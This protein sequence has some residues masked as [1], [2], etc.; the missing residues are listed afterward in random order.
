MT[1]TVRQAGEALM[2]EAPEA[3]DY[4]DR[5]EMHEQLAHSTADLPARRMHLAMAAEF[6]RR[7]KEGPFAQEV[8]AAA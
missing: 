5:A 2:F 7:A 4:C 1:E 6:R 8:A 3:Q